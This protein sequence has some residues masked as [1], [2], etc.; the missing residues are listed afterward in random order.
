[1][2][3][4]LSDAASPVEL[5]AEILCAR[6]ASRVYRFAAMISGN[7][8]DA[9]DLAQTALE[10]AIRALPRFDPRR[11]EI[12][13]WL[14]RIVA[15]AAGDARR[16]ARRRRLLAELLARRA[17][18]L[19]HQ[20]PPETADEALL[21][22]VRRLPDRQRAAVALRYGADLDLRAVGATLG[23]SAAGAGMLIRRAL[24]RLRADLADDEEQ[25]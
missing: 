14:W 13:G 12:D 6:Y 3:R 21:A 19:A 2:G 8:H 18:R 1:V 25:Q 23:V 15:N 11:G 10:R 20:G 16:G 4:P 24:D 5:T 17:G 7:P 22:T 9:D